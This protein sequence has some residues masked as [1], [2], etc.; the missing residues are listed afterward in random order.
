MADGGFF[1]GIVSL[2]PFQQSMLLLP[3]SLAF[4]IEKMRCIISF[5]DR[6][7]PLGGT[8]STQNMRRGELLP[9]ALVLAIEVRG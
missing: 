7:D 2:R 1:L 9:T 8:F 6:S 4:T 5:I 3:T